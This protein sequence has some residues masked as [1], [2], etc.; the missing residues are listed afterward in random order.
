MRHQLCTYLSVPSSPIIYI[1]P[2]KLG[3][4]QTPSLA[5]QNC[6][7]TN[8]TTKAQIA[9]SRTSQEISP[10]W[11]LHSPLLLMVDGPLFGLIRHPRDTVATASLIS[12]PSR[13]ATSTGITMMSM[14]HI[15]I[16]QVR[17]ENLLTPKDKYPL[18]VSNDLFSSVWC[19]SLWYIARGLIPQNGTQRCNIP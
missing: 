15:C 12:G 14:R 8:R 6:Y 9:R 19:L 3:Q 5:N 7:W 2:R 16:M 4:S 10:R 11:P 13:M 18:D 17:I 1:L